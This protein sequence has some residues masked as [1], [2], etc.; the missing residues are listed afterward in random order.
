MTDEPELMPT[1]IPVPL[2]KAK[3]GFA[4]MTPERRKQIAAKG[5]AAV[6]NEKRSYSQNKA[7]AIEAGRMGGLA[8]KAK[9]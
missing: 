8:K 9:E 5:G 1:E 6:P 7:L 3:R 4:C 2:V